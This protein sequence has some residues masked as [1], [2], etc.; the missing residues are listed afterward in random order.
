M[1]LTGHVVGGQIVPDAPLVLPEGA[2]V[3]IEVESAPA[4][5]AAEVGD[6]DL[7]PTLAEQLKEFLKY[8]T[9][10]LP[11]DAAENHDHYLYGTPKR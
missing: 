3:R 1:T 6:G 4:A 9:D 8:Q 2:K 10:E 5:V 7:G 11:P